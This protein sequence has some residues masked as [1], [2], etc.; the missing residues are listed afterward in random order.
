MPHAYDS[1]TLAFYASSAGDYL[2]GRPDGFS[3]HLTEFMGHLDK[4]AR[5]LEL[6][7][8]GGHDSAAMMAAGF[9]VDPTDGVPEIAAIASEKLGRD[10]RVLR[11]DELDADRAYDAVWANAALHHVP[12]AELLG[13]LARIYKALKPGGFH[14]ANFKSGKP[15]GRDDRNRLYSYLSRDEVVALYERA[16]DWSIVSAVE[17]LGGARYETKDAPWVRITVRT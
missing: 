4:G 13:I 2:S 15:D 10:V 1:E 14:Y 16:G 9:D 17:Y 3:R 8:G 11:F 6:G 5:V 7:C 12:R